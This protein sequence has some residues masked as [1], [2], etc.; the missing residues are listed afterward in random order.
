MTPAMPTDAQPTLTTA[1]VKSLLR[2]IGYALWLSK[3]VKMEIVG[4][5]REVLP[6][7]APASDGSTPVACAA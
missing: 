2:D 3:Q 1:E 6:P 7:A 4:G 5:A